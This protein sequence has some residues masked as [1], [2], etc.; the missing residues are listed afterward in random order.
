MNADSSMTNFSIMKEGF[1]T[2]KERKLILDSLRHAPPGRGVKFTLDYFT[3]S[4]PQTVKK[5][6]IDCT[7]LVS[8]EDFRHHNFNYPKG[9]GRSQ[10]VFLKKI[11]DHEFLKWNV[12]FK[13]QL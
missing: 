4:K 6:D 5:K 8:L 12:F 2:L 9:K 1:E 10:I 11:N 7:L 13:L 3:V